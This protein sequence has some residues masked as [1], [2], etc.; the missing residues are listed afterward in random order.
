M[1]IAPIN[2]LADKNG[3]KKLSLYLLDGVFSIKS[4]VD[5]SKANIIAGI[6]SVT[7][8]IHNNCNVENISIFRSIE[9]N[10]SITSIIF[11]ANK[12]NIIF[13]ILEVILRPSSTPVTIVEKLS[14]TNIQSATFL[15]TSVPV[16]PIPI[17]ISAFCI[18]GASLTPSP[19]I[20]TTNP[21]ACNASTIRSLVLGLILAY[22]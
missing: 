14:S 19:V 6:E 20:A 21:F 1:I 12:Y 10:T 5:F 11:P 15:T 9:T 2:I 7:K 8:L 22:T 3:V 16:I 17:P 18:A 13:L 4:L